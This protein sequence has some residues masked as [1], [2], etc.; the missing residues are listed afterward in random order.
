MKI[1]VKPTF[2]HRIF[3]KPSHV[4][5]QDSKFQAILPGA[6]SFG[7]C[8]CGALSNDLLVDANSSLELV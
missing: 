7:S 1:Q 6:S 8:S 4:A 3:P 5:N 2:E